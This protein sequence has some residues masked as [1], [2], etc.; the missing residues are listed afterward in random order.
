MREG[1]PLFALQ[2]LAAQGLKG[3]LDRRRLIGQNRPSSYE[4]NRLRG[5]KRTFMAKNIEISLTQQEA[6]YFEITAFSLFCDHIQRALNGDKE[7]KDKLLAKDL[8]D[9][10]EYLSLNLSKHRTIIHEMT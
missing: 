6:S 3:G 2:S 7:C 4:G 8:K 9:A 5:W 10:A 1:E